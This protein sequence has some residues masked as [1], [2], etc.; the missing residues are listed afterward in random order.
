MKGRTVELV[1]LIG[2]SLFKGGRVFGGVE[3][4]GVSL[5]DAAVVTLAAMVH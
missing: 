1:I 2:M 5:L 3:G 4:R